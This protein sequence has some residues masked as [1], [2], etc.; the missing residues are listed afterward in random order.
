MILILKTMNKKWLSFLIFSIS[1]G[2]FPFIGSAVSVPD[3]NVSFK[4]G[5]LT[6]TPPP[7]HH[8]NLPA[9]HKVKKGEASIEHR[10]TESALTVKLMKEMEGQNLNVSVFVCD[11]AK[12]FCLKKQQEI[13]VPAS[14]SSSGVKAGKSLPVEKKSGKSVG[15]AP[16]HFEKS[17]EF[18][19]ND[20]ERAFAE[21]RSQKLPLLIDFFGIWCPPCNHLDDMVFKSPEF[22]QTAKGRFVLLKLDS[23]EIK[24]SDLKDRYKIQ[25]LPTLIF[26]TSEGDEIVRL[27]GYHPLKEVQAQL[28]FSYANR[29][30]G[31]TSIAAKADDPK[32]SKDLEIHKRAA[33]IALD[34]GE[35][36]RALAW[37]KPFEASL[38][39]KSDPKLA[40]LYKAELGVAQKKEDA[41][42][43]R[44]IL[45]K[46]M[47]AFPKSVDQVENASTLADLYEQAG[48]A[49]LV[50]LTLTQGYQHA[51]WLIANSHY[52]AGSEYTAADLAQASAELIERLGDP[53]ETARAYTDCALL[54]DLQ[55]RAE[56][57]GFSRGAMLEKAYCLGK[58][59]KVDESEAIYKEGTKK[60]PKEYTFHAGLARL[61]LDTG[62]NPKRALESADRALKYA[63]GAQR[64]KVTSTRAKAFEALGEFKNAIQAIDQELPAT[65][66]AFASVSQAKLREKLLVMRSK[67]EK[68][69][70]F[71]TSVNIKTH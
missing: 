31:F 7:G 52:L 14:S 56:G 69:L 35:S 33:A 67:L 3:L 62:K 65:Q 27:L 28:D 12:T 39:E 36:G 16:A 53:V 43:A 11:Q 60:F 23:D 19:V 48:E 61:M 70:L 17:T 41:T 58:A 29:M 46:W 8:F 47:K 40:L 71:K 42:R 64:Q 21:A 18:Y 24:F 5:V 57:K 9:P 63:Y 26:T 20:P 44:E 10:L 30:E 55:A 45:E 68:R 22:K 13:S 34:R 25:G 6:I 59:G 32:N 51:H 2:L 49:K 38:I 15:A 37:L 1:F 4:V 66:P 50:K 54:Y